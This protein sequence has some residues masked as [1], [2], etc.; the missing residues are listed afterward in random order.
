M[1]DDIHWADAPSVQL[2]RQLIQAAPEARMLVLTMF[3]DR[4]EDMSPELTAV[5]PICLGS[6]E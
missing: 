6:R 3:R 5:S 2:L 1:V 4:S